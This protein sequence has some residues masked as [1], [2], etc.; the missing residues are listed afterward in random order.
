MWLSSG[1][2]GRF[3]KSVFQS[4]LTPYD[5]ILLREVSKT[6]GAFKLEYVLICIAMYCYR[7]RSAARVAIRINTFHYGSGDRAL[8]MCRKSN[9]HEAV[10]RTIHDVG[11]SIVFMCSSLNAPG[12]QLYFCIYETR[13]VMFKVSGRNRVIHPSYLEVLLLVFASWRGPV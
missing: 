1:T 10:Q 3:S 12:P 2:I 6:W 11:K 9:M 8:C 7:I 13:Q 4:S 5:H